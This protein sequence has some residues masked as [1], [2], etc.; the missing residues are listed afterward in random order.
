MCQAFPT[1]LTTLCSRRSCLPRV[2]QGTNELCYNGDMAFEF[3]IIASWTAISM[4]IGIILGRIF[5]GKKLTDV[6]ERLDAIDDRLNSSENKMPSIEQVSIHIDNS[7]RKYKVVKENYDVPDVS[8]KRPMPVDVEL[9][10]MATGELGRRLSLEVVD[11]DFFAK[12]GY[13]INDP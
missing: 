8:S 2:T 7:S 5:Y 9:G 3:K 11:L 12:E 6:I 4:V 10:Q 13:D 1:N